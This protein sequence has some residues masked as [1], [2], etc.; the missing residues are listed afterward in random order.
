MNIYG[1]HAY[2]PEDE[3][4]EGEDEEESDDEFVL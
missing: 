2:D 4:G 3:F 1:G